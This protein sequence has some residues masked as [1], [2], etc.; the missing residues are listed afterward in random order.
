M[1]FKRRNT[2]DVVVKPRYSPA[3]KL[4]VAHV[5]AGEVSRMVDR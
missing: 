1:L 4:L 5:G 2:V 3:T